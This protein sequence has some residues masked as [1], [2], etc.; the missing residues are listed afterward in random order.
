[1]FYKDGLNSV[2]LSSK[3]L[4]YGGR[5]IRIAKAFDGRIIIGDTRTNTDSPNRN[6]YIINSSLT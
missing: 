6:I 1:M 4:G 5:S 3:A 2:F